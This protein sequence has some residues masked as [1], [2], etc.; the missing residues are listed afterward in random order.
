MKS[1]AAAV[2]LGGVLKQ[3]SPPVGGRRDGLQAG[4]QIGGKPSRMGSMRRS[5]K[6]ATH[7]GV[8]APLM[9]K[10]KKPAPRAQG[11]GLSVG[12]RFSKRAPAVAD[13]RGM[14]A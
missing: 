3:R 10:Q 9:P 7:K 14:L 12:V 11:A 4:Q 13:C 1:P 2:A 6:D 5:A 8:S